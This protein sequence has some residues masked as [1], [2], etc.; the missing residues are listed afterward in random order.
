[1]HT[2]IAPN[3]FLASVPSDELEF[4]ASPQIAGRQRQQNWCW[5]ASVQIVLNY[6][7]LYVTQEQVV[8]RIYGNLVDAPAVP[9]Q[10]LTALSGWAPDTRGRYSSI[11]ASPYVFNGT[12]IVTDLSN[13]WPFIVILKGEPINHACILTGVYYSLDPLRQPFFHT[14]IIRD[15]WPLNP[16]R[17]ELSWMEF[18]SRLAFISRVYVARH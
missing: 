8:Q 2:Q 16:S 5:A 6:H 3:L 13:H 10:I 18:N 9:E 14:A 1:M 17:Q 4:N 15:P 12:E 11:H 7:G